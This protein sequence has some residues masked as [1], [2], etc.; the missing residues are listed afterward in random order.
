[1]VAGQQGQGKSA[2]GPSEFAAAGG[3]RQAL[4]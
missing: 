4:S 1:M 3:N 2:K